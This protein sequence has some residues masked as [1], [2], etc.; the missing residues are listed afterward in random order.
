MG[1]IGSPT[2]VILRSALGGALG[3]FI[4]LLFSVFEYKLS[5]GY[6]PY[7]Y[8]FVIPGLPLVLLVGVL[9]GAL[10]G[11]AILLARTMAGR[12]FGPIL[13]GVI[14]FVIILIALLVIGLYG[15]S[16]PQDPEKSRFPREPVSWTRQ[17]VNGVMIGLLFG[18]LP[19]LIAQPRGKSS[20]SHSC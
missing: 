18:S 2:A 1:K 13:R 11:G 10:V 8:L 6:I 12:E 20:I 14:G 4:M 17:A 19:G 5:L 9:A 15:L 3:G 7:P 16:R